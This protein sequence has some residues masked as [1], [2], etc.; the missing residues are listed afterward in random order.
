MNFDEE[1]SGQANLTPDHSCH[2]PNTDSQEK[3]THEQSCCDH[4]TNEQTPSG[5]PHLA[6]RAKNTPYI[7]PMHPEVQS[8]EPVSCPS[9]GMALQAVPTSTDTDQE[10]TE[11]RLITYRLWAWSIQ[12]RSSI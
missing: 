12:A 2:V 11:L 4:S 6:T 10:T 8:D 5:Q 7:C 1:H 9:C 3:S